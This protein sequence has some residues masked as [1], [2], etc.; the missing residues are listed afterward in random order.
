MKGAVYGGEARAERIG[1]ECRELRA[2]RMV[3]VHYYGSN[4]SGLMR[5]TSSSRIR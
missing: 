3:G 4:G 2:N 5:S 1:G